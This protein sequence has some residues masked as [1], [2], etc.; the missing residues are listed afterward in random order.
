MHFERKM[1]V[2]N[3]L[4]SHR[5]ALGPLLEKIWYSIYMFVHVFSRE[6]NEKKMKCILQV[7]VKKKPLPMTI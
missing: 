5:L 6:N 7:T 1:E 3:P 4:P 2:L